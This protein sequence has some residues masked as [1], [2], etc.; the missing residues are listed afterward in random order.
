M[1]D[2]TPDT[3]TDVASRADVAREARDE[4]IKVALEDDSDHLLAAVDEIRELESQKR[5]LQM[6]SPEFHRAADAIERKARA[7]FGIARA[8]REVGEALSEN[9]GE[10]IEE[11][12]AADDA[13]DG[14][15]R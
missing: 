14:R 2:G 1:P 11:H 4:D 5:H 10:S 13:G 3:R 15:K 7:V 9:Q 8:Q 12:A 6:S